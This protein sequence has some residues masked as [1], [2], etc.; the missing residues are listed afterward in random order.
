[1][2]TGKRCPAIP[3]ESGAD[4]TAN[5][6]LPNDVARRYKQAVANEH[7][8][9]H[10]TRRVWLEAGAVQI[11]DFVTPDAATPNAC[12]R[13]SRRPLRLDPNVE[14]TMRLASTGAA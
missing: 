5:R 9:P 10:V 12:R 2:V 1:M 4:P 6:A 14:R 7:Q 13:S 3:I 11:L 8:D